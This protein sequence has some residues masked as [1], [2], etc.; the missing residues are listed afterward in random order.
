MRKN[1]GKTKTTG[2]TTMSCLGYPHMHVWWNLVRGHM[3]YRGAHKLCI[4][5]RGPRCHLT[6]PCN[7]MEW[8]C[9]VLV[10]NHLCACFCTDYALQSNALSAK[11]IGK[12]VEHWT[13]S[14][15]CWKIYYQCWR[16]AHSCTIHFAAWC[17][18]PRSSSHLQCCLWCSP[19]RVS[20]TGITLV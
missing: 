1:S 15:D 7:V 16:T 20:N 11:Q 6:K 2:V 14:A 4:L 10:S 9:L 8:L 13:S 19:E 12:S 18:I 3:S 17:L 5:V